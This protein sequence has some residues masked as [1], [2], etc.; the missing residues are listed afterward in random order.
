ME[1]FDNSLDKSLFL[2]M[3]DEMAFWYIKAKYWEETLKEVE[4]ILKP[5][6]YKNENK[7]NSF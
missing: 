6:E 3:S 4:E 7:Q 5:Y 1:N 2:E